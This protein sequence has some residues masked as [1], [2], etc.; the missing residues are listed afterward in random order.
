MEQVLIKLTY[1]WN[2]NAQQWKKMN[3]IIKSL[4]TNNSYGYDE[5]CT[6]ILKISSPF[7]SSPLNYICNTI[8]FWGVFPNR[9]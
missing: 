6:K 2:V 8:L 5:I 4:K 7:T 9:L 1:V 3:W